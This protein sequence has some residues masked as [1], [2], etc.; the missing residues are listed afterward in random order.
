MG[1]CVQIRGI[2]TVGA[3]TW[4]CGGNVY[5]VEVSSLALAVVAGRWMPAAD[6][7]Q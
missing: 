1:P 2:C 4:A 7:G 3:R 5:R 6:L